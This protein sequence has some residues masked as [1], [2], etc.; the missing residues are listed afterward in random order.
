MPDLRRVAAAFLLIAFLP[1]AAAANRCVLPSGRIVY[2]DA[3][4]DSIGGKRDREVKDGIS[5][6]PLPST[7]T[8]PRKPAASTPE[9]SAGAPFRK[10]ANSPILTV[11]YD[12]KD[13]RTGI[14]APEVENAIRAG[15]ALWNAGCNVNYEYLGVCADST[16]RDQRAIDYKV[17]WASWD[18]S[19]RVAGDASKTVREHAIAAAS[20][21]VGVALNRDVDA[22]AFQR[23]WRRSIV[24]EFGHVVGIGHSQDPRDI[25]YSGGRQPTPTETDLAACNAAVAIRFGVR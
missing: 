16:A 22:A 11:C 12:P 1:Q 8:Q 9:R 20:P 24:H 14:G 4:C 23:Q 21:S 6:V 13:A 5:V 18:D 7:A 15:I 10:A 25:M 19:L 2:T 17:W 3:S